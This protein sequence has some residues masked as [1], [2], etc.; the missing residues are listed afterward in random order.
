MSKK[1]IGICVNSIEGCSLC[2]SKTKQKIED[3]NDFVCA[4]CGEPLIRKKDKSIPWK[5]IIIIIAV[6]A[7]GAGGYFCYEPIKETIAELFPD[8]QSI[9]EYPITPEGVTINKD[10]ITLAKV[11]DTARLSA[12]VYPD[13]VLDKNKTIIWKSSNDAIAKVDTTGLVTA[14]ANGTAIIS[15]YSGNGFSATCTVTVGEEST[16]ITP[17][18]CP[19]CGQKKSEC[20][21]HSTPTP[22][23][24]DKSISSSLQK[25]A[26]GNENALNRL[27]KQVGSTVPVEGVEN[28]SNSYELFHDVY[29]HG[30]N[31]SI[32]TER[33]SNNTILTII[34]E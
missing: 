10:S 33:A 21:G 11:G 16:P 2:L 13:S 3:G 30:T 15:A 22:I 34:V 7:L 8:D 32:R 6:M 27:L 26:S 31:Y 1:N 24:S 18:I 20:R 25:I 17:E 23:P 5:L 4:V 14:V 28:I 19:K 29:I 12:N 9:V